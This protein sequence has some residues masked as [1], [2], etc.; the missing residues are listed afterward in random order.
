MMGLGSPYN[1]HCVPVYSP[2]AL[3]KRKG[4]RKEITV[5]SLEPCTE[6]QAIEFHL[7][8][9]INKPDCSDGNSLGYKH[10]VLVFGGCL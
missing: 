4:S 6:W 7:K 5:L 1:P 2:F 9:L 3:V 10:P 8:V